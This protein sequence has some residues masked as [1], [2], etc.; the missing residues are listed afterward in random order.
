MKKLLTSLFVITLIAAVFTGTI[1]AHNSQRK[2]RDYDENHHYNS[3][4]RNYNR[5]DLSQEQINQ[6]ADLREDFYNQTET[7]QKQIRDLKYEL[8]NLEFRGASNREIGQIEDELE[9]LL[10]EMDEKRIEHQQKMESVLTDEQLD[11]LAENRDQYQEN[12][13]RRF[14]QDYNRGNANHMFLGH[15]NSFGSGMMGMMG[16]G[17]SGR[18]NN[19]SG[20]SYNQNY[21]Y[22]PGWCH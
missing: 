15:H 3:E 2:M 16:W 5:I 10:A 11:L 13:E 9:E 14:D 19:P 22:G 21:G 20:R 6:I 17:F 8:S 7:L 4:S 12:Y 1:F 18:D